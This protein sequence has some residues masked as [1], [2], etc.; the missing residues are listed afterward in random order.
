VRK[1]IP[2]VLLTHRL[3]THLLSGTLHIF[4]KDIALD[5][6]HMRDARFRLVRAQRRKMRIRSTVEPDDSE[7][8]TVI[9]SEDLRIAPRC[10]VDGQAC[11][12]NCNR[13]DKFTACDHWV[14]VLT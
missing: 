9:G 14:S 13:I 1:N 6:A 7:V 3:C 12:S 11:G 10:A 8:Q 2:E 4:R 5:I